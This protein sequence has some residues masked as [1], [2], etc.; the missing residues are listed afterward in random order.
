MV[1]CL[2]TSSRY[3]RAT[4]YF[5]SGILPRI[6]LGLEP[7]A[8]S[9]GRIR[10]VASP[11]LTADDIEQINQGYADRDLVIAQRT[12][13]AMDALAAADPTVYA[14][15]AW[16]IAHE[17]LDIRFAILREHVV[18]GI[19]HEKFGIF[20]DEVDAVAFTGSLNE[21]LAAIIGNFEYI[22]VFCSWTDARRVE[23]KSEYFERLWSGDT[24][25]LQILPFPAVAHAKLLTVLP[26][27]YPADPVHSEPEREDDGR[28]LRPHQVQALEAWRGND[29]RGLLEMATGT[30]KTFTALSE[31]A[32]MLKAGDA[33]NVVIL[34]PYI[35]IADQWREE[36]ERITGSV[37]IVCHSQSGDWKARLRT[38]IALSSFQE[39]QQTVIVAL[40]DT[41][42]GDE[43]RQ[44]AERL[45]LPIVLVADEVHNV[46]LD[47]ADLV[48]LDRYQYRLGLSATP[49]R[50]L[51][52]LGT[53]RVRA[54]FDRIVFRYSLAD[55]I[56]AGV[57]TPYDYHP[58][59][60]G[61]SDAHGFSRLNGVNA[62]KFNKFTETFTTTKAYS[63]GYGLVYCQPLQLEETKEWL[64]ITLRKQIH[65]F[66]AEE[67]LPQRRQIL[68][69]FGSGFYHLLVAMRCLD[70]G[71]DVPPT[72]SA[73]LLG[74]SENPKQFVQRRGRVLRKYPGKESAA[75]YDFV[76]LPKPE[77]KSHEDAL[78]KELTRFAE[79]ALSARN[80][81]DAYE[82]VVKA[83]ESRGIPLRE[84][85][86][87]GV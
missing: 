81:D 70:E 15:L 38:Q 68:K 87:Q 18:R 75:I 24:P 48:L 34:A 5:T 77:N 29:R 21:T 61:P 83:A 50:Y 39:Q 73:F 69:D 35:A 33:R 85:I 10:L 82:T 76:Y 9:A 54:Y 40:Y 25:R 64:G 26:I 3:D 37:P 23:E 32:A 31:V 55:A 19:Y 42:S 62:A 53:E 1:P 52:D 13:D 67:D 45:A 65:T 7:F 49:D 8:R 44:Q 58:I 60:C 2:A 41:A 22:D 11:N 63:D 30:G 79:F 36:V 72:R 17:V 20:A 4:G 78:R 16:L 71:V 43:F 59:I 14:Q 6:V 56:S 86:Q 74:S 84:Y 28:R 46:T 57:L 27:E 47:V 66:T 80:A 12:V 51:D